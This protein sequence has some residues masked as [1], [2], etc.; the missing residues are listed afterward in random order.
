MLASGSLEHGRAQKLKDGGYDRFCCGREGRRAADDLCGRAAANFE[1]IAERY[2]QLA[3]IIDHVGMNNSI[4]IAQSATD[5]IALA[6]YPNVTVKMK[7]ARIRTGAHP[8]P[9]MSA[10]FKRVYEAYGA[11]RCHWETDITQTLTRWLQAPHRAFHEELKFLSED[12]KDWSWPLDLGAIEMGVGMFDRAP[13][14]TARLVP[15]LNRT[16]AFA[17]SANV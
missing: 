3:L 15:A 12:D 10:Q 16:E 17:V 1:R 13:P 6:K 14:K 9:N 11:Q 4:P 5:T 7:A 8:Y 2:P